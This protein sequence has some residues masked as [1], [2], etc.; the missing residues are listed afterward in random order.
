MSAAI[1]Q[2]SGDLPIANSSPRGIV[3]CSQQQEQ[4]R[5]LQK[6]KVE[7]EWTTLRTIREAGSKAAA[8]FARA[9]L[10]RRHFQVHT[11]GNSSSGQ[12]KGHVV[13]HHKKSSCSSSRVVV[14][15]KGNTE[16]ATGTKN[17]HMRRNQGKSKS[18]QVAG[19]YSQTMP[20]VACRIA[21][22]NAPAPPVTG[23]SGFCRCCLDRWC[24]CSAVHYVTSGY[25]SST[26]TSCYRASSCATAAVHSNIGCQM[27]KHVS[28]LDCLLQHVTLQKRDLHST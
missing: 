23:G 13:V 9:N 1:S 16:E 14:D 10:S 27:M 6:N 21:L 25:P 7:D 2:L 5:L 24:C 26:C 20:I 8:V 19:C 11:C 18:K 12:D 17:K 4:Q 28:C 15:A 22:C 3:A